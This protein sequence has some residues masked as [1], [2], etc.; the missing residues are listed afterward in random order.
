MFAAGCR[1]RGLVALAL[2]AAATAGCASPPRE[3]RQPRALLIGVDGA[4]NRVIAPLIDGGELPHF[5][6]LARTGTTGALRP[7]Y[8]LLSPRVWTSIAT[9][10]KPE[11]HGIDQWVWLDPDGR[12]RLYMGT[13]RKAHA[14]WNILSDRGHSVGVVNWLM[15]HPPEKINGV[16]IS[17]HAFPGS[18]E[19]K[20][21][22]AAAFAS[23]LQAHR[24]QVTAPEAA[25][26]YA[27][28]EPWTLRVESLSRDDHPSLTDAANPFTGPGWPD[29][30]FVRRMRAAYDDDEL[31]V[32]A[33]LAVDR[34]IQPDLL[35]V[36]LPGVDRVSHFL[37]DAVEPLEAIPADRR[38][39]SDVLAK[40]RSALRSYYRFVDAVIGRL[41]AGRGEEDLVMV[42]SDHGFELGTQQLQTPGIHE[43][44]K[45]RDGILYV[46]GRGVPRGLRGVVLGMND[47]APTLLAWFGLGHSEDMDG[48]PAPFLQLGIPPPLATYETTAIERVGEARPEVEEVIIDRLR[49][50]GYVE[51]RGGQ[52]KPVE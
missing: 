24:G 8:P 3:R 31:T 37:W 36:Y 35:M 27:H 32:R 41:M 10:K 20:L 47:V 39:P 16:M 44:D 9:G 50:L 42:M 1:C 13:D 22:L 19:R 38:L 21:G 6:E 2:L 52:R 17:D 25:A 33:A 4:T 11:R 26:P 48:R 29:I 34:E 28:P 51:N 5:A 30:G 49:E 18:T 12:P 45:A 14:L 7:D 46:R 43:S 23:G 40:H 15:T